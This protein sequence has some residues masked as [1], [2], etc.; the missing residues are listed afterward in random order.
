VNTILPA[1]LGASG[2]IIAGLIAFL[3]TRRQTETEEEIALREE[4]RAMRE[5]LREAVKDLKT[6]LE[7]VREKAAINEKLVE[8]LSLEIVSLKSE[9]AM[10]RATRREWYEGS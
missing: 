6:Q 8:K 3:A 5:E 1:I 2:V 4:G 7:S 10:L 9:I